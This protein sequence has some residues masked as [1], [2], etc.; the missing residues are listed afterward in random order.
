DGE[1]VDVHVPDPGD[2]VVPFQVTNQ[3][4][5]VVEGRPERRRPF[6][7][8]DASPVI[9]RRPRGCTTSVQQ[10]VPLVADDERGQAA[11]DRGRA[12]AALDQVLENVEERARFHGLLMP[13]TPKP[14]LAWVWRNPAHLKL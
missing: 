5:R 6:P 14:I 11:D 12:V 9:L 1:G 7:D 4:V 2:R 3:G 13:G 8:Q 10:P